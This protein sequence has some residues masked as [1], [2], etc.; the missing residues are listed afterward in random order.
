MVQ[1]VPA[2]RQGFEQAGLI[3]PTLADDRSTVVAEIIAGL[4]GD[5]GLPREALRS[6]AENWEQ[7]LPAFLEMLA[8]YVD[9]PEA[10]EADADPL[11]FIVHLFGQM[12]ETRAYPLLMRFAAMSS[13]HVDRVLGDGVTATFSRVTASVF[14][15]DPRRMHDVILD[16]QADEFI[17]NELLEALALVTRDG[18]VDRASTAA[19]LE[20]CYVDLKPQY[21]SCVWAGWQCAI[22]YLGL[23]E[24]SDLVQRAFV[25][26][27]I[28]PSIM[29]FRH[30]EQDLAAVLADPAGAGAGHDAIGYFGDVIAELSHWHAFSEA[31]R[32]QPEPEL[33]PEPEPV[34][35]ALA[36]HRP[37]VTRS[38]KPRGRPRGN[39]PCPCGSGRKYKKCCRNW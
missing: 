19:F 32:P 36:S 24:F 39:D 21:G 29:S 20:Q 16:E 26:G 4:S 5:K 14:D 8:A 22:S 9:D 38:V 23:S 27:K 34:D 6:A 37:V 3:P 28:D 25:S 35:H 2:R 10:N 13:N 7:V 12:R 31:A 30:F 17:R 11:F 1:E 33:E 15:G 18:R